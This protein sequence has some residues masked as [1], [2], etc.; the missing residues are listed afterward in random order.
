MEK[1]EL[2]FLHLGK[3]AETA[4]K[5]AKWERIREAKELR[6]SVNRPIQA[7]YRGCSEF[8]SKNGT[9]CL[10][11]EKREFF[12]SEEIQDVFLSLCERSVHSYKQ[13]V[14]QGYLT[15]EG[16]YRAGIC[17]TAVYEKGE[18]VHVKDISSI[19]LRLPH[20][21]KGC[22]DTVLKVVGTEKLKGILIIGPPGS[23]KTTLLRDLA[24]QLGNG[25]KHLCIVDERMEIAGM[26]HGFPGFDLGI[27]CDVLNGYKKCDGILFAVRSMAPDLILCDE[28]GD[29]KDLRACFHAMKCGV[30]MV[31]TMHAE[32]EQELREKDIFRAM[33]QKHIFHWL[34]T[35]GRDCQ[36]ADIREI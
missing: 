25:Q 24:R 1:Q 26:S 27:S 20:E 21:V 7:V 8:L 36:V 19:N 33:W 16:G 12:S 29:E 28:F 32:N 6:F 23:G 35:L 11:T 2:L 10:P 34:V 4:L 9:P 15:I 13:E 17:G 30:V 31:A 14:C 18:I 3:T 5:G 22:A